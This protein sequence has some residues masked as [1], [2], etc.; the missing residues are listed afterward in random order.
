MLKYTWFA[1]LMVTN[2][3][4][5]INNVCPSIQDYS[6]VRTNSNCWYD[7]AADQNATNI[8][9]SYGYGVEIHKVTAPDGYITTLF[10]IITYSDAGR[11]VP[12]LL[13]HGFLYSGA[14]FIALGKDSIGFILADAGYDVWISNM[15]GTE[16][17]EEHIRLSADNIKFWNF[18]LDDVS[19]KDF[20]AQLNYILQNNQRNGKII[21]IGHS[22]GGS[23]PLMYASSFPQESNSVVKLFILLAP[24]GG[25]EN[26]KSSLL[27][28]L[29]P[30]S[31]II[32]RLFINTETAKYLSS[33]SN[34]TKL[35]KSACGQDS[36]FMSYCVETLNSIVM[37]P[38]NQIDASVIPIFFNQF[39]AGSSLKI[40]KHLVDSIRFGLRAYD[41][42]SENFE[43]YGSR[44]PPVYNVS[45]IEV[46]TYI[47]Y[48]PSDWCISDKDSENLYN[49]LSKSAK[50]HGKYKIE[51]IGFNHNDFLYGRRAKAILYNKLLQLIESIRDT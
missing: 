35:V 10:R 42:D 14:A 9:K 48:S 45:K 26:S 33:K 32:V 1:L 13:Q 3:N 34:A 5:V 11:K 21:Y 18:D 19:L 36:I 29:A 50:V 39:P 28:D 17:S 12:V 6:T 47:V 43:I 30:F 38:Q 15:R 44:L 31:N 49:R 46:P 51:D 41:Y 22:I 23:I 8:I 4:C 24:N 37:G 7:V 40:L 2:T 27:R 16:Y 20:P 25:M